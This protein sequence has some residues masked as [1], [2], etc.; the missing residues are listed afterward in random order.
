MTEFGSVGRWVVHQCFLSSSLSDSD[1]ENRSTV[2]AWHLSCTYCFTLWESAGI[3]WLWLIWSM[4]V[5]TEIVFGKLL[6]QL[7]LKKSL[8]CYFVTGMLALFCSIAYSYV[9]TTH[10]HI[11]LTWASQEI[12]WNTPL[13]IP[14]VSVA[15]LLWVWLVVGIFFFLL[16]LTHQT[17]EEPRTPNSVYMAFPFI[18]N[19]WLTADLFLSILGGCRSSCERCHGNRH[20][21]SNLSYWRS[22]FGRTHTHTHTSRFYWADWLFYVYHLTISVQSNCILEPR[23]S[24]CVGF[25]LISVIDQFHLR[26]I[27]SISRSLLVSS[28]VKPIKI[29]HSLLHIMSAHTEVLWQKNIFIFKTWQT[30][31]SAK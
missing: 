24:T 21:D 17:L 31:L 26:K 25:C 27:I 14:L 9:H 23:D 10:K 13:K 2:L 22:S 7:K 3:L 11:P 19:H 8:F 6:R 29:L 30:Q 5:L 12:S 15:L 28:M 20:G 16:H 4:M 18:L 1:K